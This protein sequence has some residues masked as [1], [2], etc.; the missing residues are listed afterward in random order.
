M[1]TSRVSKHFLF[2]LI[3]LALIAFNR[4]NGRSLTPDFYKHTCPNLVYTIKTVVDEVMSVAPTLGGPLMR[5]HFHDCFVRGCDGS[6]LL[7]TPNKTEKYAIPNLSIRGFQIID[8]VKSAVEKVCPGIVSCAD[9]LAAVARDVTVAL[10]GPSWEVEFGRRDGRVSTVNEALANLLSPFANISTLKQGFQAKGLSVK[11]LVVLSGGHTVGTSH[12]A[13]FNN[14]L[15]NFTGKGIQNDDA[16]PTLD[17][18]YVPKLK[19]KCKFGDRNTLVEMDPGSFK[20]FDLSYFSLVAKRRGLFQSDAALL[21]DSE[22]RAY[23]KLHALKDKA[24]FFKDFADSMI[25]MGRI[26]V[27]TGTQ[28]EIRKVCTKVN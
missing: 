21:D 1:A 8:K 11:D 17:Y 22:T 16:D 27:L 13:A 6:V 4:A 5:M 12:C 25:K 23:V 24:G 15:Y 18:E 14:R 7:D 20:T 2:Q 28:G 10:N 9:V 26:G 3:F 19:S